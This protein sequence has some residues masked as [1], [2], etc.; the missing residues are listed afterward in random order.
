MPLASAKAQADLDFG[1]TLARSGAYAAAAAAFRRVL[2]IDPRSVVAH[3][4]L[5]TSLAAQ[6]QLDAAVGAYRDALRIDPKAVH[7]HFSLGIVLKRQRRLDQAILSYQRA[8]AFDPSFFAAFNNLGSALRERGR[9]GEAIVAFRHALRIDATSALAHVNLGTALEDE[10]QLEEATQCYERA[11]ALDPHLAPAHR[12]LGAIL[13]ERT[14]VDEGFAHFRRYAELRHEKRDRKQDRVSPVPPHRAKHDREQADFL[15][16]TGASSDLAGQLREATARAINLPERTSEL[17]SAS[18]HLDGGG[19]LSSPAIN[20]ASDTAKIEATWE[21]NTPKIVVVDDLLA[22]EGLEGLRRFCWGSTV[23]QFTYPDG[24]LGAF[25][26]DGFASPL[27]AQISEELR[28]KFPSIFRELPLKLWWAFKCDSRLS[29]IGIHAD[30]AAV[31]V[32]LWITPDDANLDAESGGLVIWDVPAPLEW[33]YE[34]YNADPGA[35][36]DFLARSNAK[37]LTVPYRANRAVIFDSDLF[38]E[39]DRTRF[40]EGYLN[41][42]INITLLYG[43]RES[44][45]EGPNEG[46]RQADRK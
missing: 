32:N 22:P 20:P 37:S 45:D 36:R 8:I 18:F 46:N 17:I 29:G 28:A 1:V 7:V 16:E 41:R 25:P 34:K 44:A 4:N 6:G 43:L 35:I 24:Y 19:R 10:R 3:F 9:V 26:E 39:T 11:L 30:F 27:L 13:V 42:R 21:G 38:H 14:L 23:W 5:G 15:M 31:N 33:D 40:K 2:A 12:A